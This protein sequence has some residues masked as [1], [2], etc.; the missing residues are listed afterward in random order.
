MADGR[1][2]DYTR[3]TV[4]TG[5]TIS[6]SDENT[7]RTDI[8]TSI[9][10]GN[11]VMIDLE[12]NYA[13]TSAPTSA[14]D[15]KLWYDSS[16]DYLKAR[17]SSTWAAVP[18]DRWPNDFTFGKGLTV[19]SNFAV[20]GA[21][22]FGGIASFSNTISIGAGLTVPSN[23]SVQ[24]SVSIASLTVPSIFSVQGVVSI[25][26]GLSV[27]SNFS[28]G[29]AVSIAS[30]VVNSAFSSTGTASIASLE[31]A[32]NFAV[33][34][35]ATLN[36][37]VLD[38]TIS[39]ASGK[40]IDFSTDS[41]GLFT[42]TSA[43]VYRLVNNITQAGDDPLGATAGAWEISDDTENE[44][45]LGS[46]TQVTVSSGIFSFASTGYWLIMYGGNCENTSTTDTVELNLESTNDNSVYN[47]ISLATTRI[48]GASLPENL[49]NFALIKVS[50]ISND[51]IKLVFT[52]SSGNSRVLGNG[53]ANRTSV[54]FIKLADI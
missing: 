10:N 34:G 11:D 15:G 52:A 39:A 46:S 48:T 4:S 27:P 31:I 13:S 7:N 26:A 5:G 33:T 43:I 38:G 23:F 35:T 37:V 9:N 40:G 24:G 18:Y 25:G 1:I 50:S 17:I 20:S 22:V 36:E 6:S 51:K 32:S 8:A 3:T 14:P 41:K 54:S 29:G 30:L 28:V 2:T 53:G 44:F 12:Q 16:V 42:G 49:S 21:A 19:V 47:Q 45:Y